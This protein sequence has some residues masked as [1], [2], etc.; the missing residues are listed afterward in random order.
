MDKSKLNSGVCIVKNYNFLLSVTQ[1][2]NLIIL[3]LFC[4]YVPRINTKVSPY[5]NGLKVGTRLDDKTF[6]IS[7]SPLKIGRSWDTGLKLGLSFNRNCTTQ[8]LHIVTMAW[9]LKLPLTDEVIESGLVQDFDA[10]LSGIGQELG[11]GAY[12]MRYS[13]GYGRVG[14]IL[15]K[16]TVTK[17]VIRFDDLYIV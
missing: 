2:H 14:H 6:H 9:A 17:N 15:L 10:S 1:I 8:D 7:L 13:M 11:A 3:C 4:G 16:Y 12:S 5:Y